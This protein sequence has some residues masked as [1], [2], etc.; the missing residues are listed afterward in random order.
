VRCHAAAEFFGGGPV[1][2]SHRIRLAP[3]ADL[4]APLA[5]LVGTYRV[6]SLSPMIAKMTVAATIVVCLWLLP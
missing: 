2:A 3:P 6:A 5:A 1:V 4:I